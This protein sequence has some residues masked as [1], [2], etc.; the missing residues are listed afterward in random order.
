[1]ARF[2]GA[3][4]GDCCTLGL[5]T[6]VVDD[7]RYST[8]PP[9]SEPGGAALPGHHGFAE[10]PGFCCTA[11]SRLPA[12]GFCFVAGHGLGSVLLAP[13]GSH[14]INL[15]AITA[16]SSRDLIPI[17]I[18]RSARSSPGPISLSMVRW[19]LPRRASCKFWRAPGATDYGDCRACIILAA[20]RR[21]HRDDE[22]FP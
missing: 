2:S 18:R 8:A 4:P 9:S 7:N 16:R 6:P 13:F 1:M 3:F 15:A 11:S 12:A 14:A 10:F 22:R 17:P 20:N 5:T 19:G 21:G